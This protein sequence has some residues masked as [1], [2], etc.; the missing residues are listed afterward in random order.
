MV[1][2]GQR[3]GAEASSSRAGPPSSGGERVDEPPL[4]FADAQEEQQL[5]EELRDHGASPNRALNEAR[6][7]GKMLLLFSLISLFPCLFLVARRLLVSVC[8]RKEL[9]HRARDKYGALDQMSAELRQLGSSV[10][11]LT[12]SRRP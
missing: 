2:G 10:T 6:F 9:E 5:W 11:P 1:T 4:H 12:P 3:H 8:W 7:P